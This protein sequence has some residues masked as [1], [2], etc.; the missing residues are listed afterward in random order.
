MVVLR[1]RV[2]TFCQFF[3][4]RDTRKL[5]DIC[6]LTNSSRSVISTLPTATAR[7]STFF[8]WNFT[9]DLMSFTLPSRDS[10]CWHRVGNL[11]ALLR[12]GPSRRGICLIT[13]SDARNCWY[14]FA[15]FLISFLFLLSFLSAST[16]MWSMPTPCASSQCLASPS[17]QILS[18]GRGIVGSFTVPLKRLSFCGSYC[19]R[20]ICSSTVSVNLRFFSLD[21]A[22]RRVRPSRRV[23]ELSLLILYCRTRFTTRKEP[24]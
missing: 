10:V 5:T 9:W 18:L 4:R 3:L 8:S 1:Y 17:M 21:L 24:R 6:T 7:Q 2:L 23:S 16:S 20:P 11:P 19:L 13:D 14:F 22:R 15:S 12:P